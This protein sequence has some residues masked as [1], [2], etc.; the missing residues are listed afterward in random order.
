MFNLTAN[1][2][3]QYN[4]VIYLHYI[5]CVQKHKQYIAEVHHIPMYYY[6]HL[7]LHTYILYNI[8]IDYRRAYY[9]PNVFVST[10]VYLFELTVQCLTQILA[11]FDGYVFR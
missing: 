3:M 1:T 11:H 5:M 9:I 8:I 7:M 6:I 10:H 4:I 2:P